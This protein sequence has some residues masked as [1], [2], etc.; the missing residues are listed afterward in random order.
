MAHSRVDSHPH[1]RHRS[2]PA[3]CAPRYHADA[4][5][6]RPRKPGPAASA[7]RAPATDPRTAR[8]TAADRLL[9]VWLAGSWREWRQG[10]ILVKPETVVR[11]SHQRFRTYW[12]RKS[13]R[14]SGRP[15]IDPDIRALIRKISR[16]NPL[17]GT[18]RIDSELRK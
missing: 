5:S 18:P 12:A 4:P 7:H 14:R 2:T 9:W 6:P 13:R 10:L 8:L 11:W 16:D 15:V 1:A 3:R 17:W